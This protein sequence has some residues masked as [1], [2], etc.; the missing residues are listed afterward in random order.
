[1]NINVVL[2]TLLVRAD[3]WLRDV[4]GKDYSLPNTGKNPTSLII[5]LSIAKAADNDSDQVA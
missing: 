5:H 2:L 1:M 4:S 3:P